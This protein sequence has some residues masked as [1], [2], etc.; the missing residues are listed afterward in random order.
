MPELQKIELFIAP[1]CPHCPNMIKL[2]SEMV[3]NG[4]IGKLE[5]I[6]IAVATELARQSNIR[7]VPTFRIGNTLLTGVHN[8]DE[9]LEWLDKSSD[10]SLTDSF[11]QQFEEGKLDDIIDRAGQDPELFN[12]LLTMLT[13]LE[14]PLTS[15]IGISAVFEHFENTEHL[16]KL[17]PRLCKLATDEHKSIRVDIAHVLGLTGSQSAIPCLEKLAGDEFDDVR[18]TAIDSLDAINGR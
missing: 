5:I 15:R 12:H 3:K 8:K 2:T 6:N 13:D 11:N 17:V 18:E 4:E 1:G 16:D 10:D 7:S 9:L 14:T